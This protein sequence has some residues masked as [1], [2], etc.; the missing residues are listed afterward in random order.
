MLSGAGSTSTLSMMRAAIQAVSP[1][2]RPL[3]G[4][5]IFR[6]L[7]AGAS[8]VDGPELGDLGCRSGLGAGSSWL[9][10]RHAGPERR[11]LLGDRLHDPRY[12]SSQRGT[13]SSRGTRPPPREEI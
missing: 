2:A 12:Q 3:A 9:H 8:V 6:K 13:S 10:D 11:D 5:S 1:G 7:C 4:S